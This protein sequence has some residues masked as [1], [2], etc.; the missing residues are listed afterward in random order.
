MLCCTAPLN[1]FTPAIKHKS[2]GR[3]HNSMQCQILHTTAATTYPPP[4]PPRT[5]YTSSVFC[6]REFSSA[7]PS[8]EVKFRRHRGDVVAGETYT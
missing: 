8:G 3:N 1:A 6:M 2:H 7:V 4:Q 5:P